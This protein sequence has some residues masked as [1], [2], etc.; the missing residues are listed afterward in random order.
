MNQTRKFLSILAL[1][2]LL[3][4]AFITP[5]HAFD[6]R[7]GVSRRVSHSQYADLVQLSYKLTF[8]KVS[9]DAMRYLV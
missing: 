8:K 1:A 9:P 2:A 4:L 5:A 7:G 6:G 3:V